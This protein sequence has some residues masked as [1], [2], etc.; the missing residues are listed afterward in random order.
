MFM[1][2]QN[3]KD[4]NRL[5]ISIRLSVQSRRKL[6]KLC[7]KF[8]AKS[9]KNYILKHA[10]TGTWNKL[11]VP[12]L[13]IYFYNSTQT[14]DALK[15]IK[16]RSWIIRNRVEE[17]GWFLGI[18]PELRWKVVEHLISFT[19]FV[20][21]PIYPP[22]TSRYILH[23]LYALLKSVFLTTGTDILSLYRQEDSFL[24]PFSRLKSAGF[25]LSLQV[26]DR[27]QRLPQI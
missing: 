4:S 21:Y 6:S 19:I 11:T 2:K 10:L 26:K 8:M 15:C 9:N 7:N 14:L 22:W 23:L 13:F 18:I 5:H 16:T 27:R 3:R 25:I 20:H 17:R 24:V 12:T 1:W